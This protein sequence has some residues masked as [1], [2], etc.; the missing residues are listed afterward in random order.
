MNQNRRVVG[1]AV[2]V[3]LGGLL[4][5]LETAVMSGAEKPI[6][7]LYRLSDFLHGF[8]VAIAIIGAAVGAVSAG[9]PAERFGRKKVLIIIAFIF[10][11]TSLS[12]ALAPNW[13]TLLVSR[14]IGGLAIGASSVLG[15]MYIAEISPARMRGRLVAFFQFN[16][17]F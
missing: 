1:Y 7:A 11:I 15:P 16:V 4:F 2:I 14:F 10:S 17:T 3:A 12:C 13:I 6:K 9:Y 5:G 8:T